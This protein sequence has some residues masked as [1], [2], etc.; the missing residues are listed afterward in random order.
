[1]DPPVRKPGYAPE[2]HSQFSGGYA[3]Q[4]KLRNILQ[5]SQGVSLYWP[6]GGEAYV[7]KSA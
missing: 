2:Q 3:E 5:F 7:T 6:F 4:L 1:M